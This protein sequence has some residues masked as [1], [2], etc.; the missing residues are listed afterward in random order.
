VPEAPAARRRVLFRILDH[1]L[2][3]CCRDG[4]QGLFY[5]NDFVVCQLYLQVW[6]ALS[7]TSFLGFDNS[8]EIQTYYSNA[9]GPRARMD[10]KQ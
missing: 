6:R 1:E 7:P 8:V 4:N 3:V 9:A 5:A 2:N 10:D